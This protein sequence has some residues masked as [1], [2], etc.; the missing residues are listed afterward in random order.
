MQVM[1]LGMPGA[2]KGT[3]A[4]RITREFGIPHISTGDMFRKAIANQTPLGME[5]KQYLDSGRLVPD[6]LTIRIVRERLAEADAANGF[7]L[8]GFPRTL[9][10]AEALDQMLRDIGKPLDVVL[11]IHVPQEVLLSRLTGRR[12]CRAC[13]ATYHVVFQPPQREGVC[14]HCGGE[15][16]Q[17][18][19]DTEEAVRTRLEQYAQTA[20]LVEYY[21]ERGLLRQVDGEQ[22]IETVWSEV[23]RILLSIGG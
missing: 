19:D 2:G 21:R 13:G 12:V 15:L 11:Y 10:Q 8:D 3:Q 23:R 20:P 17:R 5:V 18:S 7:L 16:Y 1:L 4:E 9:A 14:D 22:P 6:D